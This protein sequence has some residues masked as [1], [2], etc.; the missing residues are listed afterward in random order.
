MTAAKVT[1]PVQPDLSGLVPY[2]GCLAVGTRLVVS[3]ISV[4]LQST[5]AV[6]PLAITSASTVSISDCGGGPRITPDG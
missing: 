4:H 3:V 5:V 6:I 1:Q 2:P